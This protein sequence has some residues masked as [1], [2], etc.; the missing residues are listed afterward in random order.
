MRAASRISKADAGAVGLSRLPLDFFFFFLVRAALVGRADRPVLST[1]ANGITGG[2]L[3]PL[4]RRRGPFDHGSA[5]VVAIT[6]R[7][8]HA[9]GDA[10]LARVITDWEHRKQFV[11]S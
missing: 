6:V 4:E 7:R 3:A 8:H 10:A 9:S 11:V 2:P 1:T 5:L